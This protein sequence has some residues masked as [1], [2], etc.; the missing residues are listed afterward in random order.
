MEKIKIHP[1]AIV[2]DG[3]KIGQNTSVWHFSHIS[4]GAT[5]GKGCNLGQNVFVDNTANIGDF[6]KIQNNVNVYRGVTLEN[7]VFCGPSMTFTNV[8]TPRCKYPRDTNGSYYLPTLVKEGA[9]IGAHAVV[10]CGVTIGENALIGSGSVV[11]KNV[12]AHAI[13]AG[14]PAKPIGWACECGAKLN[15]ALQCPDCTRKYGP[16]ENGLAELT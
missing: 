14:N 13:M 11:T 16:A 4:S 1:T 6:C 2:D 9:S 5:I 8:K 15:D 7:Y 10:V 3:A 12:P